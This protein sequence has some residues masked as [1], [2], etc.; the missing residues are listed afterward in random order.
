MNSD[1]KQKTG[2]FEGIRRTINMIRAGYD[3]DVPGDKY[4]MKKMPEFERNQKAAAEIIDDMA[5]RGEFFRSEQLGYYLFREMSELVAI[6]D[7]AVPLSRFLSK[8]GLNA[9]EKIYKYVVEA[10]YLH[11]LENGADSIVRHFSHVTFSGDGTP[12][13]Y[14][15]ME[16]NRV[17]R[18]TPDAIEEV[19]NGTDGILFLATSDSCPADVAK[20]VRGSNSLLHKLILDV[21]PFQTSVLTAEE[22]TFLFEC[23]IYAQFM[24]DLF[25]S[26]PIYAFIGE[27]GSG[28]TTAVRLIGN[29]LFGKTWDVFDVGDDQKDFDAMVTSRTFVCL[30]NTDQY[31]KWLNNK[32]AIVASGGKIARRILF[33]TNR[34]ADFPIIAMIATTSR[35]PCFRRDDVADRLVILKT[36]RLDEVPGNDF[37]DDILKVVNEN[38]L[39][40]WGEIIASLQS[41]L[42]VLTDPSWRNIKVPGARLQGFARFTYLV[43]RALGRE[44]IVLPLWKKQKLLQMEFISEGEVLLDV[45][46]TWIQT[47]PETLKSA[48]DLNSG[49]SAM[50]RQ[51]GVD[52]PYKTGFALARRMKHLKVKLEAE[53]GMYQEVGVDNQFLY[54]FRKPRSRGDDSGATPERSKRH[55]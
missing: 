13:L 37:N 23:E 41:I 14:I 32:L 39:Q 48:G 6:E 53:F 50:A 9:C 36:V 49:L 20:H 11:A 24:R 34:F 22:S 51:L 8:Y 7:G 40:L 52:W 33:K 18:V 26:N 35:T 2:D 1:K 10:I 5:C 42:Q 15:A 30:D 16:N 4:S 38:R 47:N 45:L 28:K 27:K 46:P 25:E 55:E 3:P 31:V 43:G 17:L 54:G 44:S 19:K 21:V 12:I 29:T